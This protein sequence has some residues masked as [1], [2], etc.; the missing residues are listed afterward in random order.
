MLALESI[1]TLKK[2]N[3]LS[4]FKGGEEQ[5]NSLLTE[6]FKNV[7]TKNSPLST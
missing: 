6:E 7:V 1:L 4:P 2:D 3:I 5:K